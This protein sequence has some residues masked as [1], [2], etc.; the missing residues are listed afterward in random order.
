MAHKHIAAFE[1]QLAPNRHHRLMV[2]TDGKWPK[3][4]YARRY[5]L[6]TTKVTDEAVTIFVTSGD[7]NPQTQAGYNPMVHG[8]VEVAFADNIIDM[9]NAAVRAADPDFFAKHTQVPNHEAWYREREHGI[10]FSDAEEE[11]EK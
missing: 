8:S 5:S 1:A 3:D 4:V 11:P 6:K 10:E 7:V 2:R 9:I